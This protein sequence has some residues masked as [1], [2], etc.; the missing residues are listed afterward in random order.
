MTT[1]APNG[2]SSTAG[3]RLYRRAVDALPLPVRHRAQRYYR[4]LVYRKDFGRWPSV[5][6]PQYFTEKVLWRIV[7]DRREILAVT[8]DKVRMK[9]WAQRTAPP[10]VAIPR[11]RWQDTD[12]RELAGVDLPERW[13]LKPNHR[14]SLVHFGAGA[15]DVADLAAR[16]AGWL[17]PREWLSLGEW[18]YTRAEPSLIVE[19]RIG[20]PGED[21][22]DYKFYVFE[23]EVALVQT[24][25]DRFTSHGNR[26]YSPDWRLVGCA[27]RFPT[28]R[29]VPRPD[30]LDDMLEAASAIGREF[31]FIRVDLYQTGGQIW[32]GEITPY[33][34]SGM[35]SWS[36]SSIDLE[37]GRRWRLPSP[38][39]QPLPPAP[40]VPDDAPQ[41]APTTTP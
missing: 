19:D 38:V 5:R 4:D 15:A 8:C 28:G 17:E 22:V 25:T 30:L 16:T 35:I 20:V 18:A 31:D 27:A 37:L 32:F 10:S 39:D 41:P 7:N 21:L 2:T 26:L 23:G 13:V 29:E 1:T 6:D 40:R 24:D 33:P 11:V 34:G 14:S 3:N 12:V 36:P 9:E